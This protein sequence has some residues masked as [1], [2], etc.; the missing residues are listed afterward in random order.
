MWKYSTEQEEKSH[1]FPL[2][3]PSVTELDAAMTYS[4]LLSQKLPEPSCSAPR[5]N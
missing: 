5:L 4:S 2:V 3:D 1:G